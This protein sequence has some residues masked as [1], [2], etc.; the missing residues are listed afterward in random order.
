MDIN[1]NRV[2][3]HASCHGRLPGPSPLAQPTARAQHLQP[4]TSPHAEAG[5]RTR[6]RHPRAR[7]R[8]LQI[9]V[10]GGSTEHAA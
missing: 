8:A 5:H 7:C 9:R 4:S 6:T 3:R 1:D 10:Q 2:H